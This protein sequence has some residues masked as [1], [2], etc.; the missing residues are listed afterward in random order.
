MKQHCAAIVLSTLSCAAVAIDGGAA[1][2]DWLPAAAEDVVVQQL[3]ERM[4][5]I[6]GE[7]PGD[8]DCET[9][10]PFARPGIQRGDVH[11][12]SSRKR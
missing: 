3:A 9:G 12:G 8:Q 2:A 6:A 1:E 11:G 7:K 5:E 10:L 4:K